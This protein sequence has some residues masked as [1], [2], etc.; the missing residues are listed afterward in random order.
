MF[1]GKKTVQYIR[2]CLGGFQNILKKAVG[3]Q[4]LQFTVEIWINRSNIPPYEK[5]ENVQTCEADGSPFLEM[6][7]KWSP[8]RGGC[9]LVSAGIN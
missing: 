5:K 9:N 7:I 2:D 8:E 6:K 3:K 1:K 4:Q